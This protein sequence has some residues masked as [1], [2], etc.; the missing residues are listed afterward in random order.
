[1]FSVFAQRTLFVAAALPTGYLSV[2]AL[3]GKKADK[4]RSAASLP[5]MHPHFPTVER[6]NGGI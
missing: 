5:S 4:A 3:M 6:S 1:M 2:Q